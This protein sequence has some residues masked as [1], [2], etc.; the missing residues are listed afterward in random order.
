[1]R[2]TQLLCVLLAAA[3]VQ[4][5]ATHAV[6][7]AVDAVDIGDRRELFVDDALIDQTTGE[8]D[9]KLQQPQPGEVVLTTDKPWEGNTSAYYTVF[10]DKEAG[11]YRMYYRGSHYDTQT[12][13][14][15]HPEVTC[16]AESKDGV[17]WTKPDLDLFEFDGSKK[18][19][20]VWKGI[21]THCMAVFK[22]ANPACAPEARY[23]AIGRGRP[24]G[25]KGLYVSQSPDGIHWSLIKNEPVI[26]EGYF[27]SQNLA[28]WD[29]YSKTY[30]EYHRTFVNGV[31]A[32][33][34]GTSDDFVN[35]TNPQLLNYGDAPPEHLY[36]NAVQRYE[37]APHLLI[38]FPT[39]Y[40]PKEGQRVE[41]VF[42]ASRDGLNFKRWPQAVVPEDAPE[43]RSGNRSN[44]MTWGMVQ[45][46]GNDREYSVYATEAYYTGPDSRVRRFKY[47]VDGFVSA[48]G[49]SKGGSLTTK[50]IRFQGKQLE[51][52]F[53]TR[54]QGQVRVELQDA[55]GKAISG[56]A[57][58]DCSPLTG[59]ATAQAVRWN[60]KAEL[61]SL[62]GK[63]IRI[64]FEVSAGDLYSYR[65]HD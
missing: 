20:I 59:D 5:A 27:D 47:R 43:D 40:L 24:T 10:H 39:R 65:F 17:N 14:A 62:A 51:V 45:L 16:Y 53:V 48:T 52:N 58:Q 6:A 18:N 11:L 38:G 19:N 23:K 44:Y 2:S 36:T 56:F 30:R 1:M 3:T 61:A 13:R 15:T 35:W 8:L 26:T 55:D 41:P 63:T 32:I 12:K 22:D 42:M 34:T 57:A 28:F 7:Q 9:L 4:L 33:M 31:R 64:R 29:A 60:T 50:P 21:G 25:Q 46:P 37:R 49:G 54:G